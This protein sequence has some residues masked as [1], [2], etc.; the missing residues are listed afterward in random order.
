MR[1]FLKFV[2]ILAVLSALGY[3]GYTKGRQWLAERSRPRFRTAEVQ[4][5]DLRI[6]VNASG[7]VN[8]TLKMQIGSF[9]SGPIIELFADFNDE[10]KADQILAK[11]DPR[12]YKAAV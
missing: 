6:T 1:T 2:L 12:I 3:Y 10:V 4:K 11:I 5:G 7:E 8:P 9:V